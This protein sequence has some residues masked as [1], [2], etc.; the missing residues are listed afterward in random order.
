MLG[1]SLAH[2]VD[3][4][5][6]HFCS[7]SQIVVQQISGFWAINGGELERL[8]N[9]CTSSLMIFDSWSI[10]HIPRERNRRADYLCNEL[11]DH[12]SK[13]QLKEKPGIEF[14]AGVPR[15]GWYQLGYDR[16][17]AVVGP[18]ERVI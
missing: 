7:D 6:A 3:A 11:M 10:Q 5:E 14:R 17:K 4:N 13:H 9:Y 2:L 1:I 18:R 15:D 16:P 12:K 8:H